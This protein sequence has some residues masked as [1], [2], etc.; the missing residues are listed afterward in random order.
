MLPR[1]LRDEIYKYVVF[2]PDTIN[3]NDMY[4]EMPYPNQPGLLGVCHQIRTEAL[5]L[6]YSLNSFRFHCGRLGLC[7]LPDTPSTLERMQH[8]IIVNSNEIWIDQFTLD[9]SHG[10][11]NYELDYEIMGDSWQLPVVATRFEHV[12][13]WLDSRVTD[14]NDALTAELFLDLILEII[15]SQ[16]QFRLSKDEARER[17][18]RRYDEDQM[19]VVSTRDKKRGSKKV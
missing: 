11:P 16:Y 19:E 5:P 1:E 18:I 8:I 15:D 9:I 7:E 3:F 17:S 12:K 10:L 4:S 13:S 6:Y 14:G 2:E